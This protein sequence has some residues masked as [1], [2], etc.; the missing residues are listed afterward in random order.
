MVSHHL[1]Q[2]LVSLHQRVKVLLQK[3]TKRIYPVPI[4]MALYNT[5]EHL[6]YKVLL[7]I[8]VLADAIKSP[9]APSTSATL[10]KDGDLQSHDKS[11]FSKVMEGTKS[12]S[13]HGKYVCM[14]LASPKCVDLFIL[15]F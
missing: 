5:L 1:V 11:P 13:C 6:A 15:V 7:F 10:T 9:A 14:K 8:I 2:V 3:N 12:E 4:Y